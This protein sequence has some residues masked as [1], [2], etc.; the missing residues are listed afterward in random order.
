MIFPSETKFLLK[1]STDLIFLR[2]FRYISYGDTP[3]D[4][5]VYSQRI[6]LSDT[7]SAT[8]G[9]KSNRKINLLNN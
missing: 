5:K 6:D 3:L 7:I 8:K 1:F 4:T 2:S 9:H